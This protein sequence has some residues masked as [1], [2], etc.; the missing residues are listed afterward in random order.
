M[1]PADYHH[2]IAPDWRIAMHLPA[3]DVVPPAPVCAPTCRYCGNELHGRV[4]YCSSK[5]RSAQA[6]EVAAKNA[7]Q[8][9]GWRRCTVCEVTKPMTA[10]YYLKPKNRHMTVCT[11]CA[12]AAK[13]RKK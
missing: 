5:C 11:P 6:A 3:S 10:F 1:T 12:S 9:V 4:A 13:R 8:S 7:A 2:P